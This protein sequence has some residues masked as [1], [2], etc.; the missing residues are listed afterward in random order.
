[1]YRDLLLAAIDVCRQSYLSVPLL[2]PCSDIM[3][4]CGHATTGWAEH[5]LEDA[6]NCS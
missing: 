3:P 1:M 2:V 4:Y 6:S 5:F